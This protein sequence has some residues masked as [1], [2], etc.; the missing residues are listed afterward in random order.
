MI[1]TMYVANTYQRNSLILRDTQK[2]STVLPAWKV[3]MC[4]EWNYK[5][6]GV[7]VVVCFVLFYFLMNY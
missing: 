5:I 3:S 1:L 6:W 4:V 2:M 7:F